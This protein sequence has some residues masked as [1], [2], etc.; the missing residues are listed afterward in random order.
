ML[1]AF[2]SFR[3]PA[4]LR[5]SSES[6]SG[7]ELGLTSGD[8]EPRGLEPAAVRPPAILATPMNISLR[9][10][11]GHNVGERPKDFHWLA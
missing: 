9:L 4:P 6:N 10:E 11:L 8:F 2:S 3:S 1:S 7:F 5:I